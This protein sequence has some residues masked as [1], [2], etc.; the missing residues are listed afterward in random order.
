MLEVRIGLDPSNTQTMISSLLAVHA[1]TS[2]ITSPII[3]HYGDK[4]PDR[5]RPLLLAL[6]GEMVSTLVVASTKQCVCRSI[7]LVHL[8]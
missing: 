4:T 8:R 2:A 6:C 3:G 7:L 1:L 5:K